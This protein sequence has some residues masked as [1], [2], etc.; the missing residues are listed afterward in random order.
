MLTRSCGLRIPC[1]GPSP[2][3]L[4]AGLEWRYTCCM[5]WLTDTSMRAR[6]LPAAWLVE[7]AARPAS[8]PERG[9]LRRLVATQVI[10]S[11]FGLEAGGISIDHDPHGR[12]FIAGMP[13]IGLS[14]A[15]R[16]GLVLVVLGFGPVGADI[17]INEPLAEIPWNVLHARERD[18]LSRLTGAV[19]TEAFYRLWTAK[20]ALLKATGEGLMREP[21][22]F[23]I[24]LN[25]DAAHCD[26]EPR[27]VIETRLGRAGTRTVVCAVA[28]QP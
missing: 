22:S 16:E 2:H 28:C 15:T 26:G 21:S 9:A 10:T 4:I 5:I 19:R 18:D 24:S 23:A 8:L 1:A 12:P 17:E 6:N 13:D 27:L 7:T 20:E 3:A 14:H 25:G 11:Q